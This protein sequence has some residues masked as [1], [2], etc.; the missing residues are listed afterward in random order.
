MVEG[1]WRMWGKKTMSLCS[2]EGCEKW[3]ERTCEIHSPGME[4]EWEMPVGEGSMREE[5]GGREGE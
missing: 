4:V 2:R 5:E 3:E 1:R